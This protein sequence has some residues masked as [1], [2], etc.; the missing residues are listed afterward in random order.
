MR[1]TSGA[2]RPRIC[3]AMLAANGGSAL[4]AQELGLALSRAGFSVRYCQPGN[5]TGTDAGTGTGTV[6]AAAAAAAAIKPASPHFV[7]D[8]G[9]GARTSATLDVP[10]SLGG[11]L[12]AADGLLRI[13]DAW[14]FDVFHVHNLQV[15]GHPAQVL[16]R[17]R[18]VP[19]V[20]TCH[21]SDVL[22]PGMLDRHREVA[23]EVLHQAAAVTCVSRHVSEVLRRKVPTLGLVRTIGNFVRVSWRELD[24]TARPEP[25]RFLHVSSLRPVKR[26]EL[27]LAAF[28]AVRRR[29]PAARLVIV[30]TGNG[31]RRL[32]S[33]IARGVHDGGGVEAIDGD[34]D[35]EALAREYARACALVMTSE[36][37]GFSLVTLEALQY[38]VP[39]VATATGAL[40]EVLGAGWPYLV[41]DRAGPRLAEELAATMLRAAD[42]PDP[43]LPML[44]RRVL[45]RYRGPEQVDAYARLYRRVL[46]ERD[47]V[48]CRAS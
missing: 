20:V 2:D 43:A 34:R 30:T 10:A 28:S 4:V 41:P 3:M 16:Q 26:P 18:G 12:D 35:P 14:P 44:T 11:S 36:F 15:F 19:Y 21:G 9:P 23:A 29:E 39:V 46:A 27:L 1:G 37:E 32:E 40:P 48:A 47:Q 8:A 45:A 42:A 24:F 17:L 7:L 31:M 33:L 13:H 6:A 38:G 22:N 25:G 5:G